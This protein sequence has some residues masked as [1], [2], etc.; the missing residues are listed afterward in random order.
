MMIGED[1]CSLFW[2]GQ[3]SDAQQEFYNCWTCHIGMGRLLCRACVKRRHKGHD[4]VPAGFSSGYCDCVFLNKECAFGRDPTAAADS[5]CGG[6]ARTVDSGVAR[7]V[8]RRLQICRFEQNCVLFWFSVCYILNCIILANVFNID[9]NKIVVHLTAERGSD[10]HPRAVYVYVYA[11]SQ[12]S[13]VHVASRLSPIL[14]SH[15][16]SP[17]ES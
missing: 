12:Y 6:G 7:T 8:C 4:V 17:S 3:D 1:C 5:T 14:E 15:P 13:C 16:S 10:L 2:T 9:G 11:S